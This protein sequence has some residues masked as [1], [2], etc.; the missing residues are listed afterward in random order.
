MYTL[1]AMLFY[2]SDYCL[3][4]FTFL[5]VSF[6]IIIPHRDIINY[7]IKSSPLFMF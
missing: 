3:H 4:R 7:L 1:I 5:L 6:S 2:Q